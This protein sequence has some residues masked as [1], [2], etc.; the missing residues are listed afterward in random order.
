MNLSLKGNEHVTIGFDSRRERRLIGKEIFG[1]NM[2]G[3]AERCITVVKALL[4]GNP[5]HRSDLTIP[6]EALPAVRDSAEQQGTTLMSEV[7]EGTRR[8]A[9]ELVLMS[10]AVGKMNDFILR[11][12][13]QSEVISH[14]S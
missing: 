6:S 11:N 5:N 9:P 10:R 1:S 8:A 2:P 7:F 4:R 3:P 14:K 13:I 12:S